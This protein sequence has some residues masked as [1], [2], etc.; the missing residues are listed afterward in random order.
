MNNLKKNYTSTNVKFTCNHICIISNYTKMI[1]INSFLHNNKKKNIIISN[2]VQYI[3]DHDMKFS[4]SIINFETTNKLKCNQ[5]FTNAYYY[6]KIKFVFSLKQYSLRK[7]KFNNCMTNIIFCHSLLFTNIE[8]VRNVLTKNV[9]TKNVFLFENIYNFTIY[10]DFNEITICNNKNN[11]IFKNVKKIMFLTVP[12]CTKNLKIFRNIYYLYLSTYY[13][14]N[15]LD[16]SV[17]CNVFNLQMENNNNTTG[18]NKLTKNNTFFIHNFIRNNDNTFFI[19]N[20]TQ[21]NN[22]DLKYNFIF[23]AKLIIYCC[24]GFKYNFAIKTVRFLYIKN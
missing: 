21:N 13:N 17:L 9:L 23:F 4:R 15:L 1:N 3:A 14:R 18:M 22:D 20:F 10:D 24:A 11:I 16:I 19:H 6:G 2:S 12:C 7:K 5:I 8:R